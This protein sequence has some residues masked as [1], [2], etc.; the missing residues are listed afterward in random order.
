MRPSNK[1][2]ILHAAAAVVER[3]GVTAVT[4]DSV[5]A[6]AGLTK[7][8]LMH[9]FKTRAELLQAVHQ[10]LAAQWEADLAAAVDTDPDQAT[11]AQ[12]LKAYIQVATHSASRA[13]LLFMLEGATTAEHV[14]PWNEVLDRW[15]TPLTDASHDQAALTATMARLAADGLWMHEA[16][17]NTRLPADLRDRLAA[18]ITQLATAD[19][20]PDQGELDHHGLNPRSA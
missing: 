18:R 10:H 5:S 2:I 19:D 20:Q 9:H 11:A 4:L 13:E 8:G 17:T 6:E 15:A 7:G 12:R 3:E 16:L 14:A 1:T